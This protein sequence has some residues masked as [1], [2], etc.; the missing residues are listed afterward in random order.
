MRGDPSLLRFL[1]AL[2][3]AL[4]AGATLDLAAAQS[5]D[6]SGVG[7]STTENFT[8]RQTFTEIERKFGFEIDWEQET[9]RIAYSPTVQGSCRGAAEWEIDQFAPVLGEELS[10]YPPETIRASGLKRVILCR[11]L[12]I[13]YN[14][15]NQNVE[16]GPDNANQALY[17]SVSYTYKVNSRDKQRRFLHHAL[18][19]YFDTVMK[20]MWDD[21]EWEALNP[22]GFT[23]GAYGKGG[24]YD[25]R[26]ET[27]LLSTAYPGFLNKYST[28][29][30]PD[31]KADMFAYM[32]V[33]YRY[34]DTRAR[35]DLVIRSKMALIKR[36]MLKFSPE[37]DELVWQRIARIKRDVAV[38][39]TP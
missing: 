11:D 36:R 33:L 2:L 32:M 17:V 8:F 6:P 34:V 10:L 39:T 28:G 18:F 23:Y 24:Q 13:N 19:H 4:M 15:L 38:Y 12:W 14:G 7:A 30:L 35:P 1:P 26:P 25:R 16:G 22:E 21:P 37:F 29:T 20:L 5:R 3:A 27:G 9:Y 31:D